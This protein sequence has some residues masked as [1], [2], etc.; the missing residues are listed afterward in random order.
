VLNATGLRRQRA[1]APSNSV[2]GTTRA[3][4]GV[5]R[6]RRNRFE[7][8]PTLP[9]DRVPVPRKWGFMARLKVA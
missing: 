3:Q 2:Q 9:E 1:V 4:F 7:G 6:T 8:R 5:Y